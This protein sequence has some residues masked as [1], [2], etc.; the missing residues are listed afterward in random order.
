LGN[1]ESSDIAAKPEGKD[2]LA[3]LLLVVTVDQG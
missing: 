2:R 3:D 1:L